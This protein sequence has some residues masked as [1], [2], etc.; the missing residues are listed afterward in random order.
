M[1]SS[2]LARW[3][4]VLSPQAEARRGRMPR[5]GAE[6][7]AVLFG[8]RLWASVCLALYTAMC[9]PAPLLHTSPQWGLCSVGVEPQHPLDAKQ[10]G[11]DGIEQYRGNCGCAP[12]GAFYDGSMLQ[13]V[14]CAG[15]SG[16]GATS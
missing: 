10:S 2:I 13:A 9:V 11:I 3:S 6:G 15:C 1:R 5:G 7:A 12:N 16:S 14:M 8:L 4:A